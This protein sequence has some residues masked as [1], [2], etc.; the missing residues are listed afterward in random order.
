MP[1]MARMRCLALAAA[2]LGLASCATPESRL[3]DG[4]ERAGLSPRVS[5]C[6]AERMID[7]LSL[8]QLLRLRSLGSLGDARP[9]E[10]SAADFL[11]KVRAL[12]DPEIL[13]VTTAA[14]A[15]CGLGL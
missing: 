11:H 12:K 5:A 15:R 6:M 13:G 9:G 4:L 14:L 3:R 2:A 10:L 8:A 7:R 1:R